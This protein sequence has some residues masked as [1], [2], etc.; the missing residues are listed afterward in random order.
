MAAVL[1]ISEKAVTCDM[2]ELIKITEKAVNVK[3]RE[4]MH[5]VIVGHV[6]HGKSTIIGRLL[7]DNNMLPEGKI[8]QIKEKCRRNSKPFEYAFLLDALKDEQSQ[9]ITID[10]AR[11]FFSTEKRNYIILDA[12][13][14]VEF[15]KNMVTGAARAQAALVVVDANEGV[16]E[17][18]KRHGYLL[19]MLGVTQ[20]AVLINKMDS[21][22]YSQ[23]RFES[24]KNQYSNF[25]AEIGIKAWS[26]I[27]V[28]GIQGDNIVHKDNKNMPWYNSCTVME[29]LE[30]FESTGESEDIPLRLP[31]Q[32]VYKFTENNDTRR[33]IAGTVE[34]GK[35]KVGDDI[36][37]YPSG[38][39]TKVATIEAYNT[40]IQTEAHAG[41]ATGFT[42]TEQI[43]A[44][45]GDI[46]A[47]ANEKAPIVADNVIANIFWLGK[48]PL[49]TGNKYTVKLGTAKVSAKIEKI[50]KV[51]DASV[52]ENLNKSEISKNEVGECLISF[53]RSIA[54]DPVNEN[55]SM[56][57]FVIIEDYE[58]CGGGIIISAAENSKNIFKDKSSVSKYDRI[59]SKK[60]KGTVLWF[61]G[62]SG[63]GKS[64]IGDALEWE[65]NK[66]GYSAYRL[67][68]DNLRFG[69]NK[70]CDFSEEGRCENLRRASE[71]AKLFADSGMITI[72]TF[73][74]PKEQMRNETKNIIGNDFVEIYTKTS[75]D[76]C[77][78][79]DPK[80]LYK[81]ALE[82]SIGNFTGIGSEYEEPVNSDIVI[83]TEKNTVENAVMQIMNYLSDNGIIY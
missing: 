51:I 4:D 48:S 13:G 47:N 65:L 62:L 34:T 28:S 26:Y 83:E 35:L 70:D 17:N 66:A 10:T 79:R 24:I 5:I 18:S 71:V 45:R 61:T 36:V 44:Q 38:K 76:E 20:I 82:G 19:S 42:M 1:K 52:L 58:I 55:A 81:K 63:S 12:P 73:I 68:G 77:I 11:T 59:L 72:C 29:Q 69:L 32:G 22:G 30:S 67:D 2:S 33:I 23:E 15:L 14:H 40:E 46:V 53:E 60:Q 43:Y 27:P 25:L 3:K 6:D 9:G 56:G 21:V 80:G 54:F 74:S 8:E 78:R 37:L 50:N 64:T 31:V 49:V 16:M 7:A 75:I 41:K 39:R 57:R